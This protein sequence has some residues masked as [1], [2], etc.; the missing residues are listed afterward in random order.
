MPLFIGTSGFAYKTWKP[1]FYPADL[2]EKRFLHYYA[3][4]LTA[5]EVNYTFRQL[6]SASTLNNWVDQTPGHFQFAVKAHMRITHVEKLK[7]TTGFAARFLD[8]LEPLR[9]A[10]RLG[11]ILVQLPPALRCD[12][13]LLSTFLSGRPKLYRFAFEFRH[14]SWFTDEVYA[15][16]RQH[17]AAMC[18]AESEDLHTPQVFTAPFA[19]FRMRNPPYTGEQLDALAK[20]VEQAQKEIEDVYVFFKHEDDPRGVLYAQ[21]FLRAHRAGRAAE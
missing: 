12:A 20:N 17:G 11:P 16:L 6:A 5:L 15:I 13:A 8:S 3:E 4:N 10:A 2:P 21:D 9:S 18:L 7:D 19:Y 14:Q 1:A